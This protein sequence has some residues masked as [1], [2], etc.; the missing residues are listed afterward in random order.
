MAAEVILCDEIGS[1]QDAAAILGA[2]A[3]GV[4]IIAT[5]HGEGWETVS[6]RPM[7][8]PLFETETFG[9][10]AVLLRRPGESGFAME[11]IRLW[12]S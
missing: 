5:V 3:C 4:P 2:R 11:I 12:E 1:D 10:C 7:L 8:V 9:A 6:R